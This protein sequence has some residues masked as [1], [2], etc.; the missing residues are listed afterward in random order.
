MRLLLLEPESGGHHLHHVR[1]VLQ[2]WTQR[3]HTTTLVTF[4]STLEHPFFNTIRETTED[5]L[6]TVTLPNEQRWRTRIARWPWSVSKIVYYRMF[7]ALRPV[8]ESARPDVLFLP[9]LDYCDLPAAL[10]GSPFGSVPWLGLAIHPTFHH[11]AM[12]VD[13]P[14][15]LRHRLMRRAFPRLLARP[16]FRGYFTIDPLLSPYTE[17]VYPHLAGKVQYVADPVQWPDSTPAQKESR[18]ELGLPLNRPILLLFGSIAPR[19]GVGPLLRAAL[20]PAFPKDVVLF[21]AG[22]Q[23]DEAASLLECSEAHTL[24]T[25]GRLIEHN[26]YLSDD[27]ETHAYAASDLVWLGYTDFYQMSG[28]L[29]KAASMGRPVVACN[30]GLIAWFTRRH[31][32]GLVIDV[33]DPEAVARAVNDLL[34][35]PALYDSCRT[36]GLRLARMHSIDRFA[37]AIVDC[38]EKN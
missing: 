4:P 24:R 34:Y 27:A 3:G 33:F 7:K 28:V 10:L 21:F 35:T 12:E 14:P 19:K 8:L 2:A 31:H 22:K 26:A 18:A 9:Y 11:A 38:L 25:Q 29:V 6:T 20:H 16:S 5:R 15:L 23:T 32:L 17:Q 13:T 30:Q 36:H 37:D 1:S